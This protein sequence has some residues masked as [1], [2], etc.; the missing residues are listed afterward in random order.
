MLLLLSMA[1]RAYGQYCGLARAL[2]FVGE[3]WAMLIIRD[4]LVGPRRFT[5]L[6]NGLPKIPTNIL[7]TRLREL[8]TH[9]IVRRRVPPRPAVGVLYELTEYGAEL[10]PVMLSLGAWGARSLG[11]PAAGEIVTSD[12]LIMALRSTFR[13]EA[14]RGRRL[15]VELRCGGHTLHGIVDNGALRTAAGALPGADIVI[16]AGPELWHL[17]AGELTPERAVSDGLVRVTGNAKLLDQFVEIF[18]VDP[19]QPALP[20][21]AAATATANA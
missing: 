8:E 5:D 1:K 9:G 3:R 16:E 19:T 21:H 4:L 11:D 15:A 10:E 17:M 13:A 6:K 20:H 7:S 14:A 18:R 2:E 12:S